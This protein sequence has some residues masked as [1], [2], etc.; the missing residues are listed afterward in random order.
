M[1]PPVL[2]DR[3]LEQAVRAVTLDLPVPVEFEAHLPERLPAPIES[4]VYFAVAELLA[5]TVKHSQCKRAWVSLA[6]NDSQVIAAVGDDGVG[7]ARLASGGGLMGVARRVQAFDGTP[8]VDSSPGGPT[9]IR[10]V[11]P[12]VSSS[13]RTTPSSGTDSSAS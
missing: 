10:M 5:N 12:C 11:L 9:R 13:A 4:A 1:R 7:G 6:H 2:A 3:G 8:E